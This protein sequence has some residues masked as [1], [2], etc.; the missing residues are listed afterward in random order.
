MPI[1]L[2]ALLPKENKLDLEGT[3]KHQRRETMQKAWEQSWTRR[4]FIA[5]LVYVCSVLV[6][7]MVGQALALF[8]GMVPAVFY[9]LGTMAVQ[10]VRTHWI[11]TQFYK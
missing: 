1:P 9:L 8:E 7:A 3:K 5:G 4:F 2:N 10:V 11:R 6:F